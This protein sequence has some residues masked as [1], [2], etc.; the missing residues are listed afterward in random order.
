MCESALQAQHGK[1]PLECLRIRLLSRSKDVRGHPPLPEEVAAAPK[2]LRSRGA[3]CVQPR[4][5][6]PSK[7]SPERFDALGFARGKERVT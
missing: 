2:A 7:C 3:G 5:W 4:A 6:L 1:G